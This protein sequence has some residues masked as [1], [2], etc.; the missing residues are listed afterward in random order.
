MLRDVAS[1]AEHPLEDARGAVERG[2]FVRGQVLQARGEEGVLV[3]AHRRSRALAGRAVVAS[4]L[5]RRSAGS[6]VRSIR[7]A[8][9]SRART[10][11]AVGR[12]MRSRVASSDGVS[13]PWQSIVASAAPWVRAEISARRLAHAP[14]EP[15]QHRAQA[16]CEVGGGDSLHR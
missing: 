15:G 9:S 8:S 13:G 3:L 4:R 7:P 6:G 5:E 2:E 14:R 16:M 1:L 12:W 10:R 11:V